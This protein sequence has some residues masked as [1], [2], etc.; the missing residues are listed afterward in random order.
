MSSPDILYNIAIEG[1]EQVIIDWGNSPKWLSVHAELLKTAHRISL[2]PKEGVNLP[3]VSV[4]L[5]GN[6]RW[7]V[8]SRVYGALTGPG[9]ARLYA[10]GWQQEIKGVNVKSIQWVYPAGTVE[11]AENPS[12]MKYILSGR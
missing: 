6:K 7:I 11:C 8:F 3:I 10:I 9:Q 4:D 12:F 5:T 2:I 1:K